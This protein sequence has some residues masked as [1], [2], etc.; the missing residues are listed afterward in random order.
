[1]GAS[2]CPMV[3]TVPIPVIFVVRLALVVDALVDLVVT[4]VFS[5]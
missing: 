4:S 5:A 3:A 1:M 2:V